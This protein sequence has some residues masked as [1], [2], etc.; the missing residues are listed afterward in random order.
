MTDILLDKATGDIL[1]KDGLMVLVD[2]VQESVAQRLTIKL[3]TYFGEWFVNPDYGVP[4][5]E[6]I[7]KKGVMK[8]TIDAIFRSTI[9]EDEDIL[10]I[11]T[12][13]SSIS[14]EKYTLNFTAAS[15]SGE[16][17]NYTNEF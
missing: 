12:F 15:R 13:T 16:V 7:F 9:L 14:N 5:L 11:L 4:Y 2:T 3:N 1:L 6:E 8:E 17:I 10:R